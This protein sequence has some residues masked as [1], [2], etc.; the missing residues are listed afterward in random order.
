MEKEQPPSNDWTNSEW[1][2]EWEKLAQK[3]YHGR[4]VGQWFYDNITE[5]YV[6]IINEKNK[7]EKN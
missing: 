7:P 5:T 1:Y 3:S 4:K 6:F 2:K